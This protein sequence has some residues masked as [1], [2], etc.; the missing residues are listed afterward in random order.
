M[1]TDDGPRPSKRRRVQELPTPPDSQ[2]Y[3]PPQQR[4]TRNTTHEIDTPGSDDDRDAAA[5]LSPCEDRDTQTGYIG[6]EAAE[7]SRDCGQDITCFGM[8]SAAV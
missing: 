7:E 1:M 4:S 2:P 8:V 5:P 6:R 3:T